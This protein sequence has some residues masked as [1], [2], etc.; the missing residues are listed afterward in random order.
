MSE[1]NQTA[2]ESEPTESTTN[3]NIE[4]I[5]ARLFATADNDDDEPDNETGIDLDE[6]DDI[7]DEEEKNKVFSKLGLE[8][9]VVIARM[10]NARIHLKQHI[11]SLDAI[12][13]MDKLRNNNAT[14]IRKIGDQVSALS[15]LYT[16]YHDKMETSHTI[17]KALSAL[18]SS[19]KYTKFGESSADQNA[20]TLA[21]VEQLTQKMATLKKSCSTILE[22]VKVIKNK[23]F[24]CR[25]EIELTNDGLIRNVD[26][27]QEKVRRILSVKAYQA[28]SRN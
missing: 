28:P 23:I 8:D 6:L 24:V 12:P 17:F 4:N 14:N 13:A 26:F 18:T 2:T 16:D 25:R 11:E 27:Q 20:K 15:K 7:E 9:P 1:D 10:Q 5:R 22:E 21:T 19:L 3:E